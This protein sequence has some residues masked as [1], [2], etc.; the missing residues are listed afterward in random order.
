MLSFRR[1]KNLFLIFV[2]LFFLSACTGGSEEPKVD[3]SV[4]LSSAS[5]FLDVGQFQAAII[6]SRNAIKSAPDD[7]RGHVSLAE[8]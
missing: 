3:I 7:A 5:E 4:F 1:T 8:V 2:A 6:E